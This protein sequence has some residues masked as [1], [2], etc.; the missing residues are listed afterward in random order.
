MPSMWWWYSALSL[1]LWPLHLRKPITPNSPSTFRDCRHSYCGCKISHT[2]EELTFIFCTSELT[3]PGHYVKLIWFVC[4]WK[5]NSPHIGLCQRFQLI[6]MATSHWDQ[7]RRLASYGN[8]YKLDINIHGD[9]NW[10]LHEN[11]DTSTLISSPLSQAFQVVSWLHRISKM[12]K[13]KTAL[14]TNK[15]WGKENSIHSQGQAHIGHCSS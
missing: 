3:I 11:Q 13:P 2:K 7:N 4:R 14:A 8:R 9:C 5:S 12:W 1:C 10:V 6:S 15:M